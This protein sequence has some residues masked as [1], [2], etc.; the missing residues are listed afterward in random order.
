MGKQVHGP[1]YVTIIV[2]A[3]HK[4]W[5]VNSVAQFEIQGRNLNC[6]V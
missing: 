3:A 5:N 4:H 6:M 2:T 1:H